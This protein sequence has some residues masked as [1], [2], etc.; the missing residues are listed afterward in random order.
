MKLQLFIMRKISN[1]KDQISAFV[2]AQEK[3]CLCG[4]KAKGSTFRTRNHRKHNLLIT[5]M[6]KKYLA[7]MLHVIKR[8]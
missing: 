1:G 3:K 2:L 6:K 5:K 7:V 4:K 8:L